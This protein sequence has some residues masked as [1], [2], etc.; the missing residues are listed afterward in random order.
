M[1]GGPFAND[2]SASAAETLDQM[3]SGRIGTFIER[4]S[5]LGWLHSNCTVGSSSAV[6]F[7]M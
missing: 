7:S 6:T 5:P 4:M 2:P 3:C 1:H